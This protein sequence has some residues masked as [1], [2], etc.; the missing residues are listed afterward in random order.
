MR[1]VIT[2]STVMAGW[3]ELVQ[4]AETV[5]G[6]QF[7]ADL[8]QYLTA[9]LYTYTDRPQALS[10]VLA[11]DYLQAVQNP[12]AHAQGSLRDVGDKCLLFSGLFPQ[13][14]ERRRVSINYFVD[15]GKSSYSCVAESCRNQVQKARLFSDLQYHFVGMMDVLHIIREMGGAEQQLSLVHAYELWQHTQ[16]PYAKSIIERHESGFSLETYVKNNLTK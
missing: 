16:S 7:G 8:E 12:G 11:L 9:L 15:L 4:E 13:H 10:G 2:Q 3:Y 14:A 6:V 1:R 5:Y